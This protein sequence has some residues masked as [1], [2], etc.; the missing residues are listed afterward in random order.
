MQERVRTV[1][2]H[3]HLETFLQT[4][5]LALVPMGLVNHAMATSGLTP[6]YN[7][8]HYTNIDIDIATHH[9]EEIAIFKRLTPEVD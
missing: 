9:I 2:I 6:V 3:P 8:I 1:F 7:P 4:A 5:R